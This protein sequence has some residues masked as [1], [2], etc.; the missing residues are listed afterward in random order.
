[1]TKSV[2]D[3]YWMAGRKYRCY[4]TEEVPNPSCGSRYEVTL[5]ITGDS[6]MAGPNTHERYGKTRIDSTESDRDTALL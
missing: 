6:D 3:R 5:S 2:I 4:N 1:M